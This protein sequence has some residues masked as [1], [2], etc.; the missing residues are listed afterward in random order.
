MRISFPFRAA[1]EQSHLCSGKTHH[2]G[3]HLVIICGTAIII[4]ISLQQSLMI[5]ILSKLGFILSSVSI[6]HIPYY[7]IYKYAY[8]L[9]YLHC[10][11]L[12]YLLY[13]TIT[14]FNQTSEPVPTILFESLALLG[15]R[16]TNSFDPSFT[17]TL[18]R[19]CS[20]EPVDTA[21]KK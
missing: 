10:S 11:L 15:N 5:G 4:D 8:F 18:S 1:I 16:R 12:V 21:V 9:L 20:N 6:Y 2:R 7:Y 19:R 13:F 17:V 3:D 14:F